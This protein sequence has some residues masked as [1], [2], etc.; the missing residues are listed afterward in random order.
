[1]LAS[2]SNDFFI[3]ISECFHWPGVPL[4]ITI[5]EVFFKI[6]IEFLKIFEKLFS[7]DFIYKN[8]YSHEKTL[9]LAI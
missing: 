2:E 5:V 3:W 6:I 1:M 9:Y 7:C 8:K 4:A